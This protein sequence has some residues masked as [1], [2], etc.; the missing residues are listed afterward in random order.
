MTMNLPA[1]KSLMVFELLWVF[2]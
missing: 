2:K 1:H